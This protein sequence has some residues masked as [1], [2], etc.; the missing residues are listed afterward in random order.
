[1]TKYSN[2]EKIPIDRFIDFEIDPSTRR[3]KCL[4]FS[5]VFSRGVESKYLK[6]SSCQIQFP[7]L[8]GSPSSDSG[9]KCVAPILYFHYYNCGIVSVN[10]QL[11]YIFFVFAFFLALLLINLATIAVDALIVLGVRAPFCTFSF[12]LSLRVYVSLFVKRRLFWWFVVRT[13]SFFS[14]R[15]CLFCLQKAQLLSLF[16]ATRCSS[17]CMLFPFFCRF[18]CLTHRRS[19]RFSWR[20]G[21]YLVVGSSNRFGFYR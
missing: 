10:S 4:G 1:M 17:F 7:S 18:Y 16:Y 20:E 14:R 19:S 21:F 12:F 5:V 13:P 8:D 11:I 9:D 15:S 6:F 3:I 2:Q